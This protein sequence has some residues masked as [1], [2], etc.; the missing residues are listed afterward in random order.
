MAVLLAVAVRIAPDQLLWVAILAA[1]VFVVFF[2]GIIRF[3]DKN[4]A[5]ALLEGAELLHWQQTELASKG[6]GSIPKTSVLPARPID[7][8]PPKL[9]DE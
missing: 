7:A 9:E 3:A 8:L 1:V 4:P 6:L 2:I 5:A